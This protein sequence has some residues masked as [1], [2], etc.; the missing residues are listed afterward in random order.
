LLFGS[1]YL[2][3]RSSFLLLGR[4]LSPHSLSTFAAQEQLSPDRD[5][6][7]PGTEHRFPAR[8]PHFA[9]TLR[10]FAA[11]VEYVARGDQSIPALIE[12]VPRR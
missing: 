8:V 11:V 3:L 2:L 4:G 5:Q 7:S 12:F 6:Q 10:Q 9:A 1:N